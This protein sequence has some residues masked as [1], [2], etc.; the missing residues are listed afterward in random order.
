[1]IHIAWPVS[2]LTWLLFQGERMVDAVLV[3]TGR[4][5]P[6]QDRDPGAAAT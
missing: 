6:A 1:M 3:L 5:A 4:A 2:G